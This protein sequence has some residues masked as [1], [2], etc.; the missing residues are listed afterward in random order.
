MPSNLYSVIYVY[1]QENKYSF[2][3]YLNCRI[4]DWTNINCRITAVLLSYLKGSER[5]MGRERGKRRKKMVKE[6][7]G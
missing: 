1:L 2:C 7:E 4:F 3:D 6:V 5:R